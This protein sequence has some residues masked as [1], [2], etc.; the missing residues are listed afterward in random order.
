M[1]KCPNCSGNCSSRK[2]LSVSGWNWKKCDKPSS[3]CCPILGRAQR[4]AFWWVWAGK[5]LMASIKEKGSA[6]DSEI[7][8]VNLFPKYWWK[9]WLRNTSDAQSQAVWG[10]L[11]FLEQFGDVQDPKNLISVG[12]L[13]KRWA[14]VWVGFGGQVGSTASCFFLN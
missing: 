6:Q 2:V 8:W 11:D 14:W 10:Y 12:K 13:P 3:Q 9:Y 1:S 7:P 4:R 5:Q